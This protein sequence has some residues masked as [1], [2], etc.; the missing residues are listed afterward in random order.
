MDSEQ[1]CDLCGGAMTFQ[2]DHQPDNTGLDDGPDLGRKKYT[3]PAP[4]P[5]DVA[6]EIR[7]RAWDTRRQKYG[8]RGHNSNYSR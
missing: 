7:A 2:H 5:A 4:K 6:A 3:K 1:R 8:P